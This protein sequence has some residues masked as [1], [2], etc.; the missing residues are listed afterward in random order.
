MQ[1]E[2]VLSLRSKLLQD[3][4]SV[5]QQRS[6]DVSQQTHDVQRLQEQMAEL[7][8]QYDK[9]IAEFQT[10]ISR[11]NGTNI[12]HEHFFFPPYF[13]CNLEKKLKENMVDLPTTDSFLWCP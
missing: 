7:Q 12:S 6:E 2:E 10:R 3:Y 9:Q 5:L 4:E 1:Q 8:Q 11:Q 13:I